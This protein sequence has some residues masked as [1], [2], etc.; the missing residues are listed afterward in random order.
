MGIITDLQNVSIAKKYLGLGMPPSTMCAD[1]A[2][3]LTKELCNPAN[4]LAVV[5]DAR[6]T[7]DLAVP[8]SVIDTTFGNRI[9]VF[10]TAD[11]KPP[12]GV[13]FATNTLA[14]P[15]LLPQDYILLGLSIRI[16]VEP[17]ARTIKGNLITGLP[18]SGAA[19][20]P[21]SPNEYTVADATTALGLGGGQ[22]I[23]PAELLYGLPTW[24]AAYAFMNAMSLSWNKN[25]QESLIKEPLTACA[26]IQP[27]SMAEAAGLAFTSNIDKINELNGG[28]AT[29]V[30]GSQ[31]MPETHRRVGSYTNPYPGGTNVGLFL[32]SR[33]GDTSPT[34]F[35]GIGVPQNLMQKDP[36]IF[37]TPIFWPAGHSM[38]IF[39]DV[40]DPVYQASFQRWLSISGGSGG[41]VGQDLNMPVSPQ[42]G[43]NSPSV[44]AANVGIEQTL[45][46]TAPLYVTQQVP[47][48][49]ALL[50]LGRMVFEVGLIGKRMPA[51][52]GRAVAG[53]I[54][55][56]AI[57]MPQG[58]GSLTSYIN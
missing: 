1:E 55:A 10:G 31:F 27:F 13:K 11:G 56:G 36:F 8:D 28:L 39:F 58:P 9:D 49:R 4:R 45:D 33:A 34:V 41:N 52:W 35:G 40:N 25:K 7:V 16:L 5:E 6:W 22:G 26:T 12:P 43:G 15:G 37:N 42:L 23:L 46:F 19:N 18:G 51:S 50:K 54:K 20:V 24:R 44:I 57:A 17:E 3:A 14:T 38:S 29:L 47:I 48:N 21:V 32:P 30:P 2:V 53:A